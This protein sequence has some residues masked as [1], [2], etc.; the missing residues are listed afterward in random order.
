[1]RDK[2]YEIL[3]AIS[4]HLADDE[5]GYKEVNSEYYFGRFCTSKE[6]VEKIK[7]IMD[8]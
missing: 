4:E 1:M 6:L 2:I 8:E 5:V 3:L 7:K